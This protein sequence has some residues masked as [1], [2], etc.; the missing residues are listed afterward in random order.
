MTLVA[1]KLPKTKNQLL[2]LGAKA[3]DLI[4]NLPH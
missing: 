4:Y 3:K 2:C 1:T